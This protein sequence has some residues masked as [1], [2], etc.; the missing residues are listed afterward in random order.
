VDA[1]LWQGKMLTR[2]AAAAAGDAMALK[3]EE[4]ERHQDHVKRSEDLDVRDWQNGFES[5]LL[6]SFCTDDGRTKGDKD[7][8]QLKNVLVDGNDAPSLQ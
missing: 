2:G 3:S 8:S 4:K 1:V 7:K 6:K 5:R